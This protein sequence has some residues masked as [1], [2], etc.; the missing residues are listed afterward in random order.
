MVNLLESLYAIT[1]VAVLTMLYYLVR[2]RGDDTALERFR[3]AMWVSGVGG[4]ACATLYW[5][6][7]PR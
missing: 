4:A 2:G 7:S 6:L 5:Y 3:G 1:A